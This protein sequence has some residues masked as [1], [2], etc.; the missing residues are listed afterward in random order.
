MDGGL[1]GI[2]CPGEFSKGV[3]EGLEL[4]PVS[5]VFFKSRGWLPDSDSVIN[6]SFVE[7]SSC[8]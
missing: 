3:K 5:G 7:I 6:V 1:S 8:V 4:L 2:N